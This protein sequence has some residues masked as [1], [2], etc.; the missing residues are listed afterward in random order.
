MI[1]GFCG[2]KRSGKDTAAAVAVQEGFMQLS[3]ASPMKQMLRQLLHAQGA[4]PH[5]I[6]AML[7]GDLKEVPTPYF[8]DQS[9]RHAMQTLGTEWGRKALGD[10]FWVNTLMRTSSMYSR[11]VI[12][13]VR[14]PNEAD[15]IRTKGGLV[16]RITRPGLANNDNHPSEA[17]I[18]KITV[19]GEIENSA[20]LEEFQY[21]IRNTL[22]RAIAA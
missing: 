13:D 8:N 20:S 18:D 21:I 12:S 3:F 10:D 11:V 19:D 22:L 14:F 1:I 4:R 9:P 7:E 17:L 15:A 16:F 2:R 5:E 6:Q